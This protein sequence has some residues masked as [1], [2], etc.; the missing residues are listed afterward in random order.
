[1]NAVTDY[2][3][4]STYKIVLP[5]KIKATL[6]VQ[7][8]MEIVSR[9]HIWLFEH[10][11]ERLKSNGFKSE[12][13]LIYKGK[14]KRKKYRAKYKKAFVCKGW[15]DL[16]GLYGEQPKKEGMTVVFDCT[17]GDFQNNGINIKEAFKQMEIKTEILTASKSED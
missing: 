11:R 3:I 4:P 2:F 14:G 5:K 15:H 6:V 8:S 16:T 7:N 1:M 13:Y 12:L 17:G 9:T 10:G